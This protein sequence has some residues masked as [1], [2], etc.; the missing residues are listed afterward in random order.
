MAAGLL[1][2]GPAVAHAAPSPE[3]SGDG[4]AT[5][6]EPEGKRGGLQ[7]RLKATAEGDQELSKREHLPWIDRWAPERNMIELGGFVGMFVPA[8][9][10]E[11]F[12]PRIGRPRQGFLPLARIAPAVGGRFGYFPLRF[13]GLELEGAYMPTTTLEDGYA[14]TLAA[15]RAHAVAQLPFWSVAP[16]VV[17]GAGALGIRSNPEVILGTDVDATFHLGIGA[18]AY[19]NRQ[20]AVRLDLRDT[21]TPRTGVSGGATNNLGVLLGVSFTLGRKKDVDAQPEP[22]PEPPPLTPSDRDSDGFSDAEDKCP[23]LPGVAPD[24]CPLPDDRDNDGFVDTEDACPDEP[25]IEPAGCPDP[26][27][28]GDGIEGDDDKCP[29]KPETVNKFEDDDGCPDEVPDDLQSFGGTLDGINFEL[30]KARLTKDSLPVLDK[31]VEVMLKYEHLRVEA[32]GHTD[33]SGNRDRNMK[34]SQQRADAV[35]QYLVDHGV[36]AER[37]IT[38]GAGPDEPIDSNAS[39]EGRANNRRIEFRV[40]E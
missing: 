39:P 1:A 30:G 12:E 34:L 38:R 19:I 26:D 32:S 20:I 9:D 29:D 3:A 21:I 25:G 33:N 37:I 22:E 13:L 10:L 5:E 24:G 15:G 17:V 16:F 35:R 36:S 31:A 2:I 6:A 8:Q 27:P 28:D 23:D 11:L 14:V 4:D 7:G 18:K 40:L